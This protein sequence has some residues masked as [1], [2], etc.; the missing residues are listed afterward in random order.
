MILILAKLVLAEYLIVIFEHSAY[1]C[2]MEASLSS[3]PFFF[4]QIAFIAPIN[5]MIRMK[6]IKVGEPPDILMLSDIGSAIIKN[7]MTAPTVTRIFAN[8][9]IVFP[10]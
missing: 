3:F 5:P 6:L 9:L 4:F 8:L 2:S 10:F 7:K 1:F